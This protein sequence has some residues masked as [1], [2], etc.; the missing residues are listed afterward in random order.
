MARGIMAEKEENV[1]SPTSEQ[2]ANSTKSIQK[3]ANTLNTIDYSSSD[4]NATTNAK[5]TTAPSSS[6]CSC[7]KISTMQLFYE[8]KQRFP[9]IPDNVVCECVGQNC[10]NRSACIDRLEDYPNSATNVYPQAL[11]NQ[12]IKKKTA[13]T[14]N[15][16]TQREQI[17]NPIEP[18][19][20]VQ[21]KPAPPNTLNL[22]NLNCCTRPMNR[23]T[24]Q[25]PPPPILTTS[26]ATP[27]TPTHSTKSQLNHPVNLSVNVIVSPV[28]RTPS[29]QQPP[30]S[31]CSF[32]LHQ[33]N[34]H[35]NN[36]QSAAAETIASKTPDGP[37]LTYTSS[38]YDADIGYQSRLEIT[39]AGTSSNDNCDQQLNDNA[40]EDANSTLP[41]VVASSEFLEESMLLLVNSL[42]LSLLFSLLLFLFF[43]FSGNNSP[44]N[45]VQTKACA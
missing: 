31:H 41:S 1:A 43:I 12:P 18:S 38:A 21:R 42:V 9:T 33:P 24:R 37:S 8:M 4:G 36:V 28:S 5:A 19:P 14:I 29:Q 6:S 35:M 10:H 13:T 26:I 16:T 32:T 27:T 2:F 34:N 17:T 30:Q 3:N 22:T 15:Q 45:S 39:V 11:R 40:N 25:A 20:N 7:T 44:S 23:P